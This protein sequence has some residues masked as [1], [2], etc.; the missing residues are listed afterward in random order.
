MHL[1]ETSLIKKY[2]NDIGGAIS[3]VGGEVPY[4]LH[5]LPFLD[6]VVKDQLAGDFIIDKKIDEKLRELGITPE[7]IDSWNNAVTDIGNLEKRV[8]VLEEF[9]EDVTDKME[10]Y[11]AS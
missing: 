2:E 5:W 7:A 11:D 9:K 4:E 10:D 6:E 8:S 1:V 3:D